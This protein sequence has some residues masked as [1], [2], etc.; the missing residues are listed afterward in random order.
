MR[1][2]FCGEQKMVFTMHSNGAC[3]GYIQCAMARLISFGSKA[4][5]RGV[6][7]LERTG[8]GRT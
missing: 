6:V 7:F 3:V 4:N 1:A 5:E 8:T 2:R